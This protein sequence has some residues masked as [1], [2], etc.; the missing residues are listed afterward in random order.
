[1]S[2]AEDNR[3]SLLISGINNESPF[4]MSV[5]I[6]NYYHKKY[7]DI[8][9]N[10]FYSSDLFEVCEITATKYPLHS[11]HVSS[12]MNCSTCFCPINQLHNACIRTGIISHVRIDHR[13]ISDQ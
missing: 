8:I 5:K 10:H 11:V 13:D 9:I 12:A 6:I 2:V 4:L 7:V 1:M 3:L